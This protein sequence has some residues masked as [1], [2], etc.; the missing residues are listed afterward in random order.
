MMV[1]LQ[2]TEHESWQVGCG[3][4]MTATLAAL[5]SKKI[6]RAVPPYTVERQLRLGYHMTDF[7]P[8]PLCAAIGAWEKN[9]APD[10][11]LRK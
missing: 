10:V 5:L 3:H 8:T 1:A 9:N 6:G 7:A 11:V 2:K 4:D